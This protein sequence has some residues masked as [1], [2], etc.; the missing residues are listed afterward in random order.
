MPHAFVL[1]EDGPI[2]SHYQMRDGPTFS[3][4]RGESRY[5]L[6]H[7]DETAEYLRNLTDGGEKVFR[8]L[9][10]E[11]IEEALETAD[12]AVDAVESGEFDDTL[13]LLLFAEREA[14]GARVTVIEAIASRHRELVEQ[15]QSNTN[16][17]ALNLALEDVSPA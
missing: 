17:G 4:R 7:D 10:E 2:Q 6:V 3:S 5:N 8:H 15:R 12:D 16:G 13:D 1:R 11:E 9:H 14:Y